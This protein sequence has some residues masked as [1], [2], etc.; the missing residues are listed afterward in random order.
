MSE[1]NIFTREMSQKDWSEGLVSLENI[2][3]IRYIG[4]AVHRIPAINDII[5]R[6][7]AGSLIYD[8]GSGQG[9]LCEALAQNGL[10]VIGV[11]KDDNMY[12]QS[13]DRK[14]QNTDQEWTANIEYIKGDI[15]NSKLPNSSVDGIIECGVAI[16]NDPG[17]MQKI[18]EDYARVLK[19]NG[20]ISMNT[21]HEFAVN[22][23]SPTLI[24][25]TNS[26]RSKA[27]VADHI[28]T[29]KGN[30]NN[31]GEF[32][33]VLE[34]YYHSINSPQEMRE[35][36]CFDLHIYS[37]ELLTNLAK[38]SGLELESATSLNVTQEHIDLSANWEG[39][40]VDYPLFVRYIFRK[41]NHER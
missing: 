19:P 1:P 31:L 32:T 36:G 25:S 20:I 8:A 21:Y 24:E 7:E 10:R 12:Q 6:Y 39:G 30:Y 18:F 13:I 37:E 22:P 2:I 27:K 17:K 3:P 11:E 40:T 4:D 5:A 29:S 33:K 38:Q 9:V 16:F 34:Y 14:S 28:I 35:R 15:E 23:N 41:S 26:P